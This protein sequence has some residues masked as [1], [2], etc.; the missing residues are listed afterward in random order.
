MAALALAVVVRSFLF[1]SRL[2]MCEPSAAFPGLVWW[3]PAVFWFFFWPAEGTEKRLEPK[4]LFKIP[5]DG[6]KC[7]GAH[8][9]AKALSSS[10]SAFKPIGEDTLLRGIFF[11]IAH[12]GLNKR[13]AAFS[14]VL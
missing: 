5:S 10:E 6:Q 7:E 8:G 12:N 3:R 14:V 4:P 9:I 1:L 2:Q 13:R 11:K